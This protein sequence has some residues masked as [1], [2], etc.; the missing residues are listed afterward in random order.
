M[1]PSA[2]KILYK[3]YINR[4]SPSITPFALFLRTLCERPDLAEK[5]KVV[6]IRGWQ[7]ETDMVNGTVWRGVTTVVKEEATTRS[8]RGRSYKPTD[9]KGGFKLFVEAAV[10]AGLIVD[11]EPHPFP[12][13]KHDLRFGTSQKAE[14]DLVRLVDHGVEDA[15]A[16]LMLASLPHLERLKTVAKIESFVS[17]GG[18]SLVQYLPPFSARQLSFQFW[19]TLMAN[20][21]C[22]GSILSNRHL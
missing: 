9:F 4:E 22:H 7:S 16:I 12:L 20:H 11:R 21:S 15:H 19:P 17:A 8:G 1:N 3:A 2:T 14:R 10:K 5:V 6:K 13:L 18:G